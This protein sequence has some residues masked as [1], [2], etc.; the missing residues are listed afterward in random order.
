MVKDLRPDIFNLTLDPDNNDTY[1][2][3]TKPHVSACMSTMCS[4]Q[5]ATLNSW[6][7]MS[8]LK[9]CMPSA[10]LMAEYVVLDAIVDYHKKLSIAI[11]QANQVK[12]AGGKKIVFSMCGWELCCEW[13]DSSTSWQKIFDWG[14]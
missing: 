14:K 1:R 10:K 4:S 2:R 5:I 9:L 3:M 13:K 11:L 8:S 12:V 7:Q 6:L